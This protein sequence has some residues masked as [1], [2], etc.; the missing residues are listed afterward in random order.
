MMMIQ[1]CFLIHKGI[2]VCRVQD[3]VCVSVTLFVH[4]CFVLL[5]MPALLLLFVLS[6]SIVYDLAF[7]IVTPNFSFWML[8]I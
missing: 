2:S 8:D 5:P 1:H 6:W 3:V 4:L 7:E